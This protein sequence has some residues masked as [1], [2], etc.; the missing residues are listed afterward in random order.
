MSVLARAALLATLVAASI[1][2]SAD[3]QAS[4]VDS[5]RRR[6]E[7]LESRSLDLERRLSKLESLI[8]AEQLHGQPAAMPSSSSTLQK[9]RQLK[10]GMKPDAVR[11]L[12][13]EPQRVRGGEVAFW[14]YPDNASVAFISDAVTQWSE[15]MPSR[16]EQ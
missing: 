15:P 14:F 7:F 12:L 2:A 9:W 6:V 8:N 11:A 4:Q 5:L 13:G 16:S 3:A 10:T 1:P